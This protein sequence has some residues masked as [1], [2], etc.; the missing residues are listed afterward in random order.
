MRGSV[1][2]I[3]EQLSRLGLLS[4]AQSDRV[5][6]LLNGARATEMSL[7]EELEGATLLRDKLATLRRGVVRVRRDQQRAASVLDQCE[8]SLCE[9]QDTVQQA[10]VN[11]Q[12]SYDYV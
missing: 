1:D 11:C 12:V 3:M 8:A 6:C 10:L 4:T 7:R 2:H 9:N 5:S